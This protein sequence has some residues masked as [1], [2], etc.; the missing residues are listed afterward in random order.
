MTVH[1]YDI[2]DNAIQQLLIYKQ[3]AK[4]VKIEF[5]NELT[6]L[7]LHIELETKQ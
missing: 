4:I 6:G 1:P 3:G 5:V 2:I 7:H